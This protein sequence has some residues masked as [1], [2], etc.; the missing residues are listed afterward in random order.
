V[1]SSGS[2]A[3]PQPTVG[4][5]KLRNHRRPEY[6]D[7]LAI[8]VMV[9]ELICVVLV[10]RAAYL[11]GLNNDNTWGI[12][13]AVDF[14]IVFGLLT[15]ILIISA[16]YRSLSR[17]RTLRRVSIEAVRAMLPLLV[18]L[19]SF[20]LIARLSRPAYLHGFQDWV[21]RNVDIGAIQ[22]WLAA[23]GSEFA[24]YD[25]GPPHDKDIPKFMNLG[26]PRIAIRLSTHGGPTARLAWGGRVSR[27]LIV[28]PATMELPKAGR[29][30]RSDGHEEWRRAVKPGVYVSYSGG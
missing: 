14:T 1:E 25:Q 2:S 28:G 19:A 17:S 16:L 4:E 27:D 11:Y 10:R 30:E 12:H 6:R 23:Q 29:I 21:V 7:I 3:Q 15:G 24:G 26:S 20:W 9:G 5:G 22:Q 13:H 18:F 8:A